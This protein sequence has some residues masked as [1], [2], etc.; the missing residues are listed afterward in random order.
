VN[1]DQLWSAAQRPFDARDPETL[2][3]TARTCRLALGAVVVAQF[4]FPALLQP[5]F[6]TWVVVPLSGAPVA[7]LTRT[8][9][10]LG[11]APWALLAAVQIAHARL[12]RR[13][14]FPFDDAQVIWMTLVPGYNVP[15]TVRLFTATGRALVALGA[16]PGLARDLRWASIAAVALGVAVP[17][18][19]VYALGGG[20]V[21]ITGTGL[22]AGAFL[23]LSLRILVLVR[24]HFAFTAEPVRQAL[25]AGPGSAVAAGAAEAAPPTATSLPPSTATSLPPSTAT[26]LPPPTATSAP[27]RATARPHRAPSPLRPIV[28]VGGATVVLVLLVALAAR[29]RRDPTDE[30]VRASE[31]AYEG[32]LERQAELIRGSS[33]ATTPAAATSPAPAAAPRPDPREPEPAARDLA[34][35]LAAPSS[36]LPGPPEPLYGGRTVA[37][38][39]ERIAELRRGLGEDAQRLGDLTV[40]RARANGLS[41]EEGAGRV[42]VTAPD[43]PGGRP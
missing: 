29:L 41:V 23:L 21:P 42:R 9:Y 15:G 33:R 14:G 32:S 16:A 22:F 4:L 10:L 38:W 13:A 12:L 26:S 17:L 20:G 28:I 36:G 25:R 5:L 39:E 27:A 3:R 40:A 6:S 11:L 37:W 30:L 31:R 19:W 24:L 43:G 34:A 7:V 8:S 18:E 1:A 35:R 2:E